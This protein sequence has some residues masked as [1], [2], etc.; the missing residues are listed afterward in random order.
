MITVQ[1]LLKEDSTEV[2]MGYCIEVRST[3]MNNAYCHMIYNFDWN[4][5]PP[6]PDVGKYYNIRYEDCNNGGVNDNYMVTFPSAADATM[7]L[8]RFS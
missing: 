6:L 4:T 5:D 3:I 8:L 7:F 1:I 2:S